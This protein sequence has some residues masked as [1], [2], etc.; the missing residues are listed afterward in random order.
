MSVRGKI[1]REYKDLKE[2]IFAKTRRGQKGTWDK[3]RAIGS[4]GQEKLV[5]FVVSRINLSQDPDEIGYF[6]ALRQVVMDMTKE[7]VTEVATLPPPMIGKRRWKD[8]CDLYAT[9]FAR[10]QIRVRIYCRL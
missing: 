10:R 8:W 9:V 1:F 5:Y 4:D 7:K 3:V 2:L 6:G